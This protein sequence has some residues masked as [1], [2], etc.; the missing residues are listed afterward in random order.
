MTDSVDASL[1]GRIDQPAQ[2]T[3]SGLAKVRPFLKWAGGKRQLLKALL[4]RIPRTYG[5]YHEP[6]VGGGALFFALQSREAILGDT[7]ARLI[8]TFRGVQHRTEAVISRL[9][10]MPVSREFFNAQRLSPIDQASDTDLAAWFIYLNRT[11][12]NGLYRVNRRGEFNVPFGRYENPKIC[13][14]EN[15]R[16]CSKALAGTTLVLGDFEGVLNHAE[17][18]DLVYFDPPY[19]PVS[20]NSSFTRYTAEQFRLADHRRLRDVALELKRRRVHVL[21]SNSVAPEVYA[22]YEKD[23]RIEKL[24]ATRFVNSDPLGRGTVTETLIS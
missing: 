20:I 8:R 14:P 9:S 6:F 2:E 1:N 16:A 18:G 3:F 10:Q 17:Q 15:L 13:D 22:L 7:N 5:K 19:I 21:L 12:Y 23:F 11:G 24:Q 4:P